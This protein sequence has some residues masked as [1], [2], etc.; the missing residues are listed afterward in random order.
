MK[1]SLPFVVLVVGFVLAPL[2]A[3][4]NPN[5]TPVHLVQQSEHVAL[6]KL[7]APDAKGVITAQVVRLL[8]GK[9]DVKALTIDLSASPLKEQSKAVA[10]IASEQ[11][12]RP[13]LLFT[14]QFKEEGQDQGN[15]K[16]PAAFLHLGGK[17]VSLFRDAKAPKAEPGFGMDQIDNAMEGTWAGGTDMLHR[18]VEFIAKDPDARIPIVEGAAWKTPIKIGKLDGPVHGMEAVELTSDGI[19]HLFIAAE[20]GDRVF[21]YDAKAKIF[22]DL[23]AAL[24]LGS[25]S[26]QAAWGDFNGDGRLDLASWDGKTLVLW[27]QGEGGSFAVQSPTV[28]GPVPISCLGL[29]VLD[30]GGKHGAGLLC[31]S[32]E[33]PLLLKP[34]GNGAFVAVSLA[35]GKRPDGTAS[36]CLIA[37]FDGDGW[38]DVLQPFAKGSLLYRG[39]AAGEFAPGAECPVALGKGRA[40]AFV[41]DFDA[42]G[43]LDVY[44]LAEDGCR[45]WHN[46]GGGNFIES[47]QLSGESVYIAQPGGF[48]GAIGDINND[49]RQDV[50]LLYGKLRPLLFFNRGFRSFGHAHTLDL[51][52]QKTLEAASAGQQAGVLADFN[53]DGTQD[54]ALALNDG[55]I[56][57]FANELSEGEPLSVRTVLPA[58]VAGPI[59]LT[60]WSGD[61]SLGAWNVSSGGAGAFLGRQEAGALKLRWTYPGRPA[62][63]QEVIVEKRPVR[64]VLK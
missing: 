17:W 37:D 1:R 60:A 45:L 44:C 61:Q 30:V 31:S 43:M 13:A 40:G 63:E 53:R 20:A 33:G 23:A 34:Q 59:T 22:E 19:L 25:K 47:F 54:M 48:A 62:Q 7:A 3:A 36:R 52:E 50:L 15:Q 42:D 55:T 18:C 46:Q 39:K 58:G 14:G 12:D 49:G 16:K 35:A 4:I 32:A 57:F 21:R 26:R 8:K 51:E 10:K 11:G 27:M 29:A 41:G 38:P 64:F 2:P 56:W 5:F 6:L 9:W 28:T 24:K